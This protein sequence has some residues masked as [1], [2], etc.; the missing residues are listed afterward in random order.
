M[1][2]TCLGLAVTLSVSLLAGCYELGG[3]QGGGQTKFAAERGLRP[4]DVAV[5]AGYR[6]DVVATGLN[7]PTGVTFDEQNRPY[8]VEAG[9][10]Y[11]EVFTKPRVLRIEPDGRA[12]VI[13]EGDESGPWNGI[14][15]HDGALYV[16]EGGEQS[17]GRIVR[18]D[19]DGRIPPL[20]SGLPSVG[21]HP[22]NGPVVGPDGSLYF[23]IGTATNS[24]VVGPDNFEFGWVRRHPEFHDIPA[25]DITLKG[26]NFT[27]E[28]PRDK[29]RKAVTGA[30]LPFGTPSQDGQVIRG[31]V[32]CTGGI[33]RIA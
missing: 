33:F 14:A 17:G 11:G 10:S 20:V 18:V 22:T 32:P 31:Q 6:V 19:L 8:V 7:F 29:N 4:S 2:K 27:S 5:P 21:D 23:A 3:P 30:Y 13:A 28:D 26:R 24:G 1:K 15:F 16:A 12:T 25:R 9:Y